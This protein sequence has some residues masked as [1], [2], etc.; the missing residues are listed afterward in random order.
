MR[1]WMGIEDFQILQTNL[2]RGHQAMLYW[3][4]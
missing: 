3:L 2:L 4:R 1:L